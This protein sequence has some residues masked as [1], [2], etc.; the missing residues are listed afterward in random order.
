MPL[1]EKIGQ[2]IACRYMGRFVSADSEYLGDLVGLLKRQKVGGLII[3]GGEVYETAHLTNFLQQNARIPLLIAADFEWGAAMRINGTTLFPP[4]MAMGA[5]ASEEL[6]YR[7]GQIT[8]TEARAMGIHMTYAPVVDVNIN[9]D[10]PIISTRSLGEDPEAVARLAAAFIRGCQEN[11][12]AATAK[13]FPGHGDTDLDSHSLLPTIKADRERLMNV[14]LY[15]FARAIQA[16]VEAIMTAHLYVPALDATPNL[17]AT[18]SYPIMTELLRKEMGFRGLIVTDALSMGGIT[19]SFSTSE[20]ALKAVHA[21]VDMLLLP[22]EP[23]EAIAALHEAVASGDIPE[24]RIDQSVMKIL[25]LKARLGLHRNRLVEVSRLPQKVATRKHLDIAAQAFE[26]SVTLVK[27]EAGLLPLTPDT[28]GQKIAVFSLSSDPGDYYAGSAFIRELEKRC[29]G[30]SSFSADAFTGKEFIQE[31]K[32]RA[33]G[34]P[35]VIFA[36]FSSLRTAKGSVDL[37]PG[38]AEVVRAFS[39]SPA[40]VIVLSFGSPYFL[41]HFPEVDAYICLYRNTPQAQAVAAKA[42]FGEI[43]VNGRLP[44]TIPGLHPVGHGLSLPRK[45][46]E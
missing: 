29:P 31:A 41:R 15:P 1:E 32:E 4:L 26:K 6:V 46:R 23:E 22:P 42:L 9:P 8:A 12:L 40:R 20:A 30:L 43:E 39:E 19:R 5:A 17:P 10:N 21:G 25:E 44:V 2:M 36:L 14:E 13:H 28:A 35:V 16:G 11:G 45:L 3:F 37:L 38:H 7:M 27:N 33:A 34:V 18:L 24:A